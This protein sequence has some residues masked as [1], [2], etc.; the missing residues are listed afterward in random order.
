VGEL[1]LWDTEHGER[2]NSLRGHGTVI[3]RIAWSQDSKRLF[4]GGMT[5]VIRWWDVESGANLHTQQAH[6]G[7]IRAL[8]VSPDDSTLLSSGEDGVIHLWDIESAALKRT[9][10]IDRP[11]ERMDISG[12]GGVSEAQRAALIALGAIEH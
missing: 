12:L 7:W 9:L 2:V 8:G 11:Y 6:Q 3:S 1:F 4:S 10:R 5:G